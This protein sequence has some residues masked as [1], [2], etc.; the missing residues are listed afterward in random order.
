MALNTTVSPDS[1]TFNNNLLSY[2]LSGTGSIAG[3]TGLTVGG[4]GGV[5]LSTSNSFMG[6]TV[7]SAGTL[8]LGNSGALAGSALDYN[9]Q[10]G[11]LNF[12]GLTFA[13]LGGLKGAKPATRQRL[14]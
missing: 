3:P 9:K 11:M 2:S 8:T 6:D 10:G 4:S 14:G 1:V 13:A 12:G 7:V 5:T